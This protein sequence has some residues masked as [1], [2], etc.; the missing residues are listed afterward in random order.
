MGMAGPSCHEW[1]AAVLHCA[2]VSDDR[3]QITVDVDDWNNLVAVYR[4][5]MNIPPDATD[6]GAVLRRGM[7]FRLQNAACL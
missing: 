2:E 4:R 6:D 5:A 7:L 1:L 3:R